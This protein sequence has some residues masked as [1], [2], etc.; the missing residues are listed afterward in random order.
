MSGIVGG[1]GS[2][3]GVIGTTELD[4]EEGTWTPIIRGNT[5]APSGQSY[6]RQNGRY[7]KIGRSVTLEF[8]VLLSTQGT[9]GGTYLLI[10][11]V[12]YSP[13][14]NYKAGGTA[15]YFEAMGVSCTSVVATIAVAD[16]MFIWVTTAA[17]ATLTRTNPATNYITDNTNFAGTIMYST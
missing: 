11:G 5:P 8:D 7:T 16:Q 3:S 4:Y 1:T 6:S 9:V 10:S 14:M 12:P 13:G 15:V 17:Q 2:K